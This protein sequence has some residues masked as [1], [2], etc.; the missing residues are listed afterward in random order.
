MPETHLLGIRHV[1]VTMSGMHPEY[2]E[3]HFKPAGYEGPW[4]CQFAIVTGYATTGEEWT[5][6]ANAKAYLELHA[7]LLRRGVWFSASPDSHHGLD[8]QNRDGP[9]SCLFLRHA[10]SGASSDMTP[11]IL[12]GKINFLSNTVIRDEWKYSSARFVIDC[13]S[14]RFTTLLLSGGVI[15]RPMVKGAN[16]GGVSQRLRSFRTRGNRCPRQ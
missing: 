16:D 11:F 10:I 2:F 6:E 7:E 14:E 12:F 3:T 1:S 4:P 13:V 5:S 9:P 15:F 8:M